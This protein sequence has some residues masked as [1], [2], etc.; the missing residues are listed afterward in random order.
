MKRTRDELQY[1]FEYGTTYS[2]IRDLI[3][4][5]ALTDEVL[6]LIGGGG[7]TFDSGWGIN[8]TQNSPTSL[9][10]SNKYKH[11][12]LIKNNP[13]VSDLDINF[14]NDVTNVEFIIS[15][16]TSD[17]V[18]DSYNPNVNPGTR[19]IFVISDNTPYKIVL[20]YK[21]GIV[22]NFVNKNGE[23]IE[24]YWNGTSFNL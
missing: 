19:F 16:L 9:L 13:D 5:I 24:L 4:S 21:N 2:R 7:K 18:I 22:Y 8:I 10:I 17:L 3:D 12:E 23:Y 6:E 20:T 15:N 11:V 1:E 14:D